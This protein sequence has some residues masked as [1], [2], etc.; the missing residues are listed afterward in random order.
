ML[1][2]EEA[3]RIVLLEATV[4]LLDVQR[5]LDLLPDVPAA[6]IAETVSLLVDMVRPVDLVEVGTGRAAP[7]PFPVIR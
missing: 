5:A 2:L 6:A 4:H 3:L 1:C 7:S